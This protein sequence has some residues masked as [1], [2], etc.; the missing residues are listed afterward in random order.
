MNNFL[1]FT[2]IFWVLALCIFSTVP[3]LALANGDLVNRLNETLNQSSIKQKELSIL[4]TLHAEGKAT[5]V[6]NLNTKEKFIPASL[7]KILTAGMSLEK[8]PVGFRFVT[9][10]LATGPVEGGQ[11]KGDL[12]LKGGGDPSFVSESMWVLV[13][14]FVRSGIKS[15]EGDLVVDDSRFDSERFDQGR[16]PQRVD[17]AYDAPVGAM[18]FNWNTVNIFVRPGKKK[19]DK[20]QVFIDPENSYIQLINKAV[21]G[22][23]QSKRN[24]QASRK[25]NGKSTDMIVI[26]GSIPQGGDEFVIY[27]GVSHPDLWSAHNL[28]SF[29]LK[30]DISIKGSIRSGRVPLEA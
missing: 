2:L 5:E 13:N 12:F 26:S 16:D 22:S 7:T 28:R 29:L 19:G 18:S 11:L 6:F 9:E 27:K 24:L 1:R 4:V 23:S 20:A 17:R 25:P 14:D 30:R 3:L 21:T 15:V 8:Y 10:L